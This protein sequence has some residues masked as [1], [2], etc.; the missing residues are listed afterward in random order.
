[1][2]VQQRRVLRRQ[3][4]TVKTLMDCINMIL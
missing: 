3:Q 2:V 1:M 4:I